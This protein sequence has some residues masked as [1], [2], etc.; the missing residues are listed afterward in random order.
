MTVTQTAASL[1]RK[2]LSEPSPSKPEPQTTQLEGEPLTTPYRVGMAAGVAL[3]VTSSAIASIVHTAPQHEGKFELTTAPVSANRARPSQTQAANPAISAPVLQRSDQIRVLESPMLIEPIVKRLQA[4]IPDLDYATI[5]ENLRITAD[6]QRLEVH[7][8]GTNPRTVQLVLEQLAQAYVDYSQKCQSATCHGLDFIESQVPQV[9][10]QIKQLQSKIETL[11][12]LNGLNNLDAQRQL[13]IDRT[14][15]IAKQKAE[16]SG[17]ILQAHQQYTELQ[18]RMSLRPNEA[19]AAYIL[20]QNPRYQVLL[21]QWQTVD[22]KLAIEFNN[23][24]V[25]N[26]KLQGLMAQ[27]QALLLQLNQEAEQALQ[28]Y[29]SDPNSKLQNPIFHE[30]VY[31]DLLQ[32]SIVTVNYLQVLKTTHQRI[33]QTEGALK[34]QRSRLSK[35]L[36]NYARLRQELQVKTQTLQHFINQ[37]EALKTKP[38]ETSFQVVSAPKLLESTGK[39]L[40]SEVQDHAGM[41]AAIGILLSAGVAAK[42]S[43]VRG[44][45]KKAALQNARHAIS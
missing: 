33:V 25:Q 31:L 39:S 19:I 21:R 2:Y 3:A 41:I 29:V 6:S 40:G 1:S 9:Q 15:E 16:V 11:H 24:K 36:Y 32:Q 13:L 38:T 10:Q 4:Q 27:H 43:S 23:L 22:Q 7:Y 45:I 14:T 35:V 37:L 20:S 12:Q 17:R 26:P 5:K 44:A 42:Q 30:K 34:Q 18:N 28:R 8:R